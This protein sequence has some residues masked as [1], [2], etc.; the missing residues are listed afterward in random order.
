MKN[1]A[2]YCGASS[3][4]QK[5]YQ[6][7]TQKLG[8]WL[9]ENNYGLVYGG[10]NKGLMNLLANSVIEKNGFVHG[11][12]T[13]KLYDRNL[14]HNKL[15]ELEI[16]N[17]MSQRKEAMLNDSIANIA[18]PGGPGT[19]EEISEAFSWTIIGESNHPCI[20]YNI[21]HYYDELETFFDSMTQEDFLDIKARNTL[22]FSDSL[23]EIGH[24]IA[25]Y[26][27]PKLRR[28]QS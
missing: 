9:V 3:G 14:A 5:I 17:N 10:G 16:V 24:F 26:L 18:L 11:I 15:S 12:I 20:F 6:L 25:N 13:Q 8:Y 21:N 22:L 28:Y 7:N 23:D 2:V 27:P 4:N 1:I 19:L